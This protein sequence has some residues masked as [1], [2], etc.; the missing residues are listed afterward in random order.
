LNCFAIVSAAVFC[1]RAGLRIHGSG[2]TGATDIA[3]IGTGVKLNFN[4]QVSF[5]ASLSTNLYKDT[6]LY[7]TVGVRAVWLL[8]RGLFKEKRPIFKLLLVQLG[9]LEP[10]TS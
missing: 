9:G 2:G 3:R 7:G 8:V 1:R 4:K 10:P 5:D 6:K